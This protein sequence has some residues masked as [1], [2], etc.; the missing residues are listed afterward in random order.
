VS[1]TVEFELLPKFEFH[2]REIQKRCVL[3]GG[4]D[5]ELIFAAPAAKRAQVEGLRKELD[6]SLSRVGAIDAG[7]GNLK[8][9]DK[10]G[11]PMAA[12]RGFDHF[13]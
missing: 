6:L 2:D 7:K 9:R 13:A 12:G 1:A 4:D 11:K 5:Y 10:G 3:S 8:I